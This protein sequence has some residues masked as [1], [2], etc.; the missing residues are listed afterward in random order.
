MTIDK[1]LEKL[2]RPD[3]TNFD[4]MH[5]IKIQTLYID[6]CYDIQIRSTPT[7]S[8]TEFLYL[9]TT[10]GT[11]EHRTYAQ[12]FQRFYFGEMHKPKFVPIEQPKHWGERDLEQHLNG[13]L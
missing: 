1:L 9:Y 3:L 7:I 13:T 12:S 5:Y 8:K 6:D 11:Q 10:Y 2:D 4:I